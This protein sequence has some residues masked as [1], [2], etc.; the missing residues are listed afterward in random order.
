MF[1]TYL[2]L[3][4]GKKATQGGIS[5]HNL[6]ENNWSCDCNRSLAFDH[7]DGQ[8]N[9]SCRGGYRYIVIEVASEPMD[10]PFDHEEVIKNAN[11]EYFE[12]LD[13]LRCMR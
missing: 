11:S 12:H 9:G 3:K 2:D 5:R 1:V 7:D 4:T 13:S 10:D 6:E 8:D